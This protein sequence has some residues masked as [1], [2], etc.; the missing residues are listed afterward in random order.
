MSTSWTALVLFRVRRSQASVSSCLIT[1]TNAWRYP[2][3]VNHAPFML[4]HSRA[5]TSQLVHELAQ[6]KRR[7]L[8]TV[9]PTAIPDLRPDLRTM[10]ASGTDRNRTARRN[11]PSPSA[12]SPEIPERRRSVP[13]QAVAVC[14]NSNVLSTSKHAAEMLPT[15]AIVHQVCET[16]SNG[17][18][19]DAA[20]HL[21]R[22]RKT[23]Y[24]FEDA[25]STHLNNDERLCESLLVHGP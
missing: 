3:H 23:A 6:D 19:D 15:V 12:V 14:R 2:Q 7:R 25:E 1:T 5:M 24:I 10:P 11:S 8:R 13:P 22:F 9:A 4:H 20:C 18:R 16:V 21:L 17:E